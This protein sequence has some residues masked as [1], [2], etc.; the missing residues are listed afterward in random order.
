MAE[1]LNIND[2]EQTPYPGSSENRINIKKKKPI[3]RHTIFRLQ[4]T[5][6]R[7]TPE[8]SQRKRIPYL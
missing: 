2:R 7:E 1:I 6:D 3:P 5:K 8:R 4:I